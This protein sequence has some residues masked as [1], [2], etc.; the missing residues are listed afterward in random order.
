MDRQT[1]S[2]TGEMIVSHKETSNRMMSNEGAIMSDH[3]QKTDRNCSVCHN[4][5]C[6]LTQTADAVTAQQKYRIQQHTQ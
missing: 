1:D 3:H 6:Q 5:I 2:Q 4:L